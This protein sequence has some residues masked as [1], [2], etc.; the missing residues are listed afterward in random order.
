MSTVDHKVGIDD[1]SE[2]WKVGT[3]PDRGTI[4]P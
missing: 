4:R 2:L 1:L 3:Y